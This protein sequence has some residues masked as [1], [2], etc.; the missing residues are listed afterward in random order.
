MLS[1]TFPVSL[2]NKENLENLA[3]FI[4][5]K[6]L[7]DKLYNNTEEQLRV[8]IYVFLVELNCEATPT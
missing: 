1:A 4:I 8:D 7:F 5:T 2:W 6:V 3:T